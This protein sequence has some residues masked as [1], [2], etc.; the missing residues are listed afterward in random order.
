MLS[1]YIRLR[2]PKARNLIVLMFI[3]LAFVVAATNLLAL[4]YCLATT[5]AIEFIDA[6]RAADHA[7]GF[8]WTA[9]SATVSSVPYASAVIGFCCQQ[10]IAEFVVVVA[11]LAAFGQTDDC[12]RL[13]FAFAVSSMAMASISGFL[14]VKSIDAVAP[15]ATATRNLKRP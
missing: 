2:A 15:L 4:Q 5:R 3:G 8:A 10:W 13:T 12:F 9:F 7:L 14:D 11:L 1:F 6:I